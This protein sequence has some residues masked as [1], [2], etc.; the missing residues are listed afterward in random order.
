MKRV[1]A[2]FWQ[3]V[4]PAALVG[5]LWGASDALF[6]WFRS[7]PRPVSWPTLPE[8]VVLAAALGT[9]YAVLCAI[10]LLLFF[11]GLQS[12]L[13]W[14]GRELGE[15]D[16]VLATA[17]LVVSPSGS[18][19]RAWL[20]TA[21]VIA[22]TV[23]LA[24]VDEYV[25][26][27]IRVDNW[28]L[29]VAYAA[30]TTLAAV[31]PVLLLRVFGRRGPHWRAVEPVL[32]AF[33]GLVA[34]YVASATLT[35]AVPRQIWVFLPLIF[36]PTAVA[37]VTLGAYRGS[38]RR[39]IEVAAVGCLAASVLVL[40]LYP[41]RSPGHA[42]LFSGPIV[43][44]GSW[45]VLAA[46]SDLDGDRSSH[47]LG[48]GDCDSLEPAR[49]AGALEVVGNGVDDNCAGGDLTSVSAPP[50]QPPQWPAGPRPTIVVITVDTLRADALG[51]SVAGRSV[52]PFID[53]LLEGSVRFERAYSTAGNTDEAVPALM[54]GMY[55]SDWHSEGTYFGVEPTLAEILGG[56]GYTT[57]A[58]ILLPWLRVA[59][60]HGFDTIDNSLGERHFRDERYLSTNET[61]RKALE[62]FDAAGD[63]PQL[64]WVH[65]FDAHMPR[66]EIPELRDWLPGDTYA[67]NVHLVDR[68]IGDLLTGLDQR[69]VL[70][71]GIIVF[72]A[73]HGEAL[74]EHNLITHAWGVW[75]SIIRVPLAIRLPGVPPRRIEE[76]VSIVDVLPTLLEY[77]GIRD[78]VRRD[79]ASLM[80]LIAGGTAPTRPVFIESEVDERPTFFAVI[81]QDMKL[82]VDITRAAYH[83]YDLAADPREAHNLIRARPEE[84]ERLLGLLGEWRDAV[85]NS[86]RLD[87]KRAVW[88]TRGVWEAK[89]LI[90]RDDSLQRDAIRFE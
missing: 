45:V 51:H 10:P 90:T 63:G 47:L 70:D 34:Y 42:F 33:L 49:W 54:S 13:A 57:G 55:P 88:P 23:G 43:G 58:T 35:G 37:V 72:A 46:L 71:D 30:W 60:V 59:S 40:S 84:T 14:R 18:G 24:A 3:I 50:P 16:I 83:L 87:R 12:L 75:E 52:T 41:T 86:A 61:T 21:A 17:R 19:R 81:D 1:V 82:S 67:Q 80:P 6:A 69:G 29:V 2:F 44:S 39:A 66:F 36:L 5:G 11:A 65:Y 77:L 27:H 20:N 25:V 15:R 26:P 62:R 76:R 89:E 38:W 28:L 9:A 53:A 8:A 64:L 73:D 4:A 31:V 79:G 32:W 85:Y 68:G 78:G 56:F 74:G 48:D 22:A 7:V